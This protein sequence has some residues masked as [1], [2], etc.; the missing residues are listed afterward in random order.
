MI[1]TESDMRR[2]TCEV[3]VHQII[4]AD[5][6]LERTPASRPR[7]PS[8]ADHRAARRRTSHIARRTPPDRVQP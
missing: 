2:A 3:I 7:E 1:A 6:G 4:S 8:G 5:D